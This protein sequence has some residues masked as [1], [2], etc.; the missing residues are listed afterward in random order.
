MTQVVVAIG[1]NVLPHSRVRKGLDLLKATF[2]GLRYSPIYR[3]APVGVGGGCFLNLVALFDTDRTLETVHAL[4]RDIEAAC[5]R[6]RS[7]PA[8]AGCMDIDLLLFGDVVR[9]DAPRLPRANIL[10]HTFVLR[11]LAELLPDARHPVCGR[12]YRELWADSKLS[13]PTLEAVALDEEAR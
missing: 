6:D 4:L 3:C 5:G 12:T 7:R 13:G 11:P 10:E 2:E 9:N 1:S 8:S